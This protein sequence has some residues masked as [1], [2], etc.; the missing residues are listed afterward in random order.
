MILKPLLLTSNRGSVL[1]C[2]KIVK[3]TNL[4]E[5]NW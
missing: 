4:E 5:M 1:R 3:N 2:K